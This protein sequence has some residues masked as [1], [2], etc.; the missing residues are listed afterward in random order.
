MMIRRL[1]RASIVLCAVAT[2]AA[3]GGEGD[4]AVAAAPPTSPTS[5][6]TPTP[7]PTANHAPEI[8]GTP[9]AAIEAGQDYSFTPTAS[10]ADNDFL[11]FSVTNKPTWAT[12]SVDTGALTGSPQDA[13]VGETQDITITVT[14]GRDQRSIGPFRIVIR[15][16]SAPPPA[17]NNA[18]T[19]SGTPTASVDVGAAYSFQ[20]SAADADGDALRFS[21]SNRP[22][23]ASFSTSSGT[24]SG[25]PAA[26]NVGNFSNI[27]ISVSD[28]VATTALPAFA[29]SV[30]G[31]DNSAPAIGGTPMT[32]VQAGQAYSFQP[33]ATDA[34]GDA[35]TWS[36][37][38]KPSWA[39]F[40]ASTGRLTGT[41]AASNVGSFANII[42]SVSDGKVSTA[43]TAFTITVQ[44]AANRAPTIS[45]TPGTSATVGTAYSFTPTAADAD[46]S[47]TLG[48]SIQ[49]K[50]TWANFTAS[51]GRLSGTPTAAGTFGNIIISVSDGKASASL[52]A[53]TITVSGGSTTPPPGNA[54]PTLSGTPATSVTVGASY[55]FQPTANDPEGATLAFS[56]SNKPGW[57]TFSTTTGRLS[58]TPSAT[59][60]TSNIVIG[61][62]D[63]THSVSLPAFSIAVNA[64]PA[65]GSATLSWVAPTQNTDGT[66]LTNLAGYRIVY[67]TSSSALNQTITISNPSVTS[68]V[69]DGLASG[70]WYFA[71][72][73]YTGSGGE[74]SQ[75]NVASKT[76]P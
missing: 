42:I 5:P 30:K 7:P 25:T 22:S 54:A 58:G 65:T 47:D 38:N 41:P 24:L 36:I 71:V 9:A 8:T 61:V 70:T 59:G 4:D 74:S 57:A 16:R 60:T 76:I 14:D 32:S 21:I 3:C 27:V 37:Q 55:S 45:G 43:L 11:E 73:A 64:A 51:T 10:D 56:I 1:V 62:S 19:I 18:P 68:Y 53:F 12:F 72:K 63:G 33:T 75:S 39:S 35:L 50:P 69:V 40:S 26:A 23:W 44:A 6:T 13:D 20:P 67:G 15:S 31:P 52:A 48:F 2:L 66:A 34:N 29:I 28:G 49:N 17:A 46:A